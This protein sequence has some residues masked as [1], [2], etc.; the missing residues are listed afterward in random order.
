M[1]SALRTYNIFLPHPYKNLE[2]G[3]SIVQKVK[4]VF[5]FVETFASHFSLSINLQIKTFR[6]LKEKTFLLV[7]LLA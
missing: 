7:Y 5:N 6:K 1:H 4:V 2:H 3:R